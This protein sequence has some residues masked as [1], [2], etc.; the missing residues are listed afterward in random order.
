[1]SR[2]A[3]WKQ[4]R[5]IKRSSSSGSSL[6]GKP[7][8]ERHQITSSFLEDS[9][10]RAAQGYLDVSFPAA[11][12]SKQNW[13]HS[14]C[15]RSS[16]RDD[17]KYLVQFK[18]SVK[19]S[20]PRMCLPARSSATDR[21]SSAPALMTVCVSFLAPS[22]HLKHHHP[23]LGRTADVVTSK[24]T[25]TNAAGSASQSRASSNRRWDI[26]HNQH[27]LPCRCFHKAES[28]HTSP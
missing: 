23:A 13:P 22:E 16:C 9:P 28:R 6:Y 26:N 5:T 20:C 15:P 18:A 3:V 1:M 7:S 25:R 24:M 27:I 8:A 10:C 4:N 2:K 11:P 19:S 17:G 14:H 12:S 21:Q